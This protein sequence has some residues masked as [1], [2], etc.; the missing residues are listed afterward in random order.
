VAHAELNAILTAREPLC[1]YTIYTT[2]FS[3]SDCA[4]MVIQTGLRRI[5]SP[6]YESEWWAASLTVF[7]EI[8]DEA[9]VTW[10]STDKEKPVAT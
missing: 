1:G 9:G 10:D 5:V 6:T 7:Q 8:Y 4:K 3:C 2:L